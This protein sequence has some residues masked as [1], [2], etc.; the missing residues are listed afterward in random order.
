MGGG[1][2]GGGSLPVQ[3]PKQ[4]AVTAQALPQRTVTEV[5]E[6]NTRLAAA[7]LTQD[8]NAP[9]KLGIPS[10]QAKDLLGL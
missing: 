5:E 4:K 7:L 9:P 3:Q 1:S 8:W 10:L 2:G 6:R